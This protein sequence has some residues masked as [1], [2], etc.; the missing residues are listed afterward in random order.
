[1]LTDV[2]GF[3]VKLI[4]VNKCWL[5]ASFLC[6]SSWLFTSCINEVEY[7]FI[8]EDLEHQPPARSEELEDIT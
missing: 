2:S 6:V 1:M 5:P 7:D 4:I 3:I 8:R